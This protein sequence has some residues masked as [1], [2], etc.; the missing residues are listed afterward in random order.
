MPAETTRLI[1]VPALTIVP[2]AGLSLIT[3]PDSAVSLYWV[4]TVPTARPAL[5]MTVAAA[6]CANPTTLGVD[7]C[8]GPLETMR[9]TDD[10]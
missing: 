4:V 2:A 7:T 9:L 1:D 3:L 5:P 6:A 10:P 8:A